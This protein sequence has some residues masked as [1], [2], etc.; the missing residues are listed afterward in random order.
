MHQ[1]R[2]WSNRVSPERFHFTPAFSFRLVITYWNDLCTLPC[3]VPRCG[4]NR[5]TVLDTLKDLDA[6]S[7]VATSNNLWSEPP[8]PRL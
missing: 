1:S 6:V 2:V 7:I 5:G 4:D 8:R 3:G